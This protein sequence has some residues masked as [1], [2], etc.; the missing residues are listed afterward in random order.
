MVP[1]L[2]IFKESTNPSELRLKGLIPDVK[3]FAPDLWA[4]ISQFTERVS[5]AEAQDTGDSAILAICVSLAHLL[6]PRKSNNF[7]VLLGIY[8][9]GLGAKRRLIEILAALGLT[10]SYDRIRLYQNKVADFNQV[11]YTLYTALIVFYLIS[12]PLKDHR[13]S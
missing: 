9:H 2:G 1:A 4:L 13:R 7:Q 11:S 12:L 10:I 8:F 6:H 5:T 3:R